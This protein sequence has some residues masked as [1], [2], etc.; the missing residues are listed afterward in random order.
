MKHSILTPLSFASV[1]LSSAVSYAT[2]IT[3]YSPLNSTRIESDD[4]REF[5]AKVE[6]LSEGSLQITVAY[7]GGL[8]FSNPELLRNMRRGFVQAGGVYGSYVA[9]D[10]PALGALYLEGAI[11]DYTEHQEALPAILDAY[12]RVF[13][14]W[15]IEYIGYIQAP[16]YDVSIFCKDSVSTLKGL[17]NKKLRVWS[18]AQIDAF[19]ELGISAQIIPQSEMYVAL[20]TG[21]VDCA[22]YLAEVAPLISLQ[23]V[24]PNE[25][26]LLPYASLPMALG[27]N[28][29]TFGSLTDAER[30]ALR[31]AGTWIGEKTMARSIKEAELKSTGNQRSG[32]SEMGFTILEPFPDADVDVFVTVARAVWKQLAEEGGDISLTTFEKITK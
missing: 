23:E 20:Q 30:K 7:D 29:S 13:E 24:A 4:V 25:A 26:Y 16:L 6:E 5:A 14:D 8:G 21:V 11:R 17:E 2:E 31:D 12:E 15:N 1:L 22:L 10:V 28:K 27:V 9:R 18:G 3:L 19:R 32:R